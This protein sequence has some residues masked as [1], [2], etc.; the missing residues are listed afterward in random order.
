[1]SVTPAALRAALRVLRRGG[2]QLPAVQRQR[3]YGLTTMSGLTD[4]IGIGNGIRRSQQRSSGRAK[5]CARR[6]RS[7]PAMALDGVARAG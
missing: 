5:S 7:V 6:V 2:R 3:H 1:M 4:T